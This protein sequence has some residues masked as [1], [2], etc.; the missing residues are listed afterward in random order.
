[1]HVVEGRWVCLQS[2]WFIYKCV[3]NRDSTNDRQRKARDVRCVLKLEHEACFVM[4]NFWSTKVFFP[5]FSYP[6]KFHILTIINIHI[7][8]QHHH[9]LVCLRYGI[10]TAAV[11][12]KTSAQ[13]HLSG[14]KDGEA[15]SLNY[16]DSSCCSRD[17]TGNPLL[18]C[19]EAC[20]G[21]HGYKQVKV[22]M[23][24]SHFRWN[25]SP[26]LWWN[27]TPKVKHSCYK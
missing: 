17:Q 5:P 3:F 19:R 12:N 20:Q 14:G 13:G 11:G 26:N 15:L 9:N 25:L 18:T 7:W 23:F 6:W 24:W 16:P 4:P 21:V 22:K 10:S 1:M 2:P 27:Y 8:N